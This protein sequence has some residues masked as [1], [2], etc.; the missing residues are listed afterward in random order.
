MRNKR[1]KNTELKNLVLIF[2]FILFGSSMT[3]YAQNKFPYELYKSR[4]LNEIIEINADL[5]NADLIIKKEEIPQI[6]LNGNPLYSQVRLKFMNKSRPI[7]TDRMDLVKLWQKTF[8]AD[9]RV[10]TLYENEY[11]FKECETEYWI[12]VQKQVAAFFP[13]ELKTGDMIS[14]FIMR[15]GGRKEKNADKWDWLFLTNEFVK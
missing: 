11:L 9:E 4:T 15:I 6:T 12:P 13:K 7:S 5:K 10:L 8:D 1:S 14:L 3:V 2:V